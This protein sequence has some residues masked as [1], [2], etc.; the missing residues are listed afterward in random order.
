[1]KLSM[2]IVN[3]KEEIVMLILSRGLIWVKTISMKIKLKLRIKIV[4]NN[5][6]HVRKL[7]NKRTHNYH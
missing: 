7:S 1:M 6:I 2:K 3:K 5:K 4:I